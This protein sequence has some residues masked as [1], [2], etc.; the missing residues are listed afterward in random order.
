[1]HEILIQQ[2]IFILNWVKR[3]DL[4]HH[5]WNNLEEILTIRAIIV[6]HD[7]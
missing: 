7:D 5:H 2:G 4:N 1:M 3:I 6:L